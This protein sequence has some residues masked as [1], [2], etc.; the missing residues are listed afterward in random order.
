MRRSKRLSGVETG[1]TKRRKQAESNGGD[2]DGEDLQKHNKQVPRAEVR[3]LRDVSRREAII[4]RYDKMLCELQNKLGSKRGET[5]I[6]YKIGNAERGFIKWP[7]KEYWRWLRMKETNNLAV[8]SVSLSYP[9]DDYCVQEQSL[10]TLSEQQ[11]N[12]GLRCE[13]FMETS[14]V[15]EE[16]EGRE[17]EIMYRHW[18]TLVVSTVSDLISRQGLDF[19]SYF[20]KASESQG[21]NQKSG[22]FALQFSERVLPDEYRDVETGLHWVVVFEPTVPYLPRTLNLQERRRRPASENVLLLVGRLLTGQEI[23][24]LKDSSGVAHKS[25]FVKLIERWKQE[26]THHISSIKCP[27]GANS[28]A[29]DLRTRLQ[30]RQK[31]GLK[32]I[33]EEKNDDERS[34]SDLEEGEIRVDGVKRNAQ[35]LL[36]LPYI[37]F[38]HNGSRGPLNLR[39]KSPDQA[40]RD[41]LAFQLTDLMLEHGWCTVTTCRER[42]HKRSMQIEASGLEQTIIDREGKIVATI[43]SR[44]IDTF[45]L[46]SSKND[47]LMY[48]VE[49]GKRTTRVANGQSIFCANAKRTLS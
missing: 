24:S 7:Q 49:N 5:E 1:K 29:A 32:K 47:L 38:E 45:P 3:R 14:D 22:F 2:E 10:Y 43:Q 16:D 27:F 23:R 46:E 33:L 17:E 19:R 20:D 13:L 31:E 35:G 44:P 25:L 11:R 41:R 15:G 40:K 28:V 6:N 39:W 36:Y 26:G 30:F 37:P 4:C 48:F 21:N 9:F 12:L 18:L 34:D 8:M 42:V